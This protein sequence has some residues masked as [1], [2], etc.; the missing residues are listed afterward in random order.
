MLI[1]IIVNSGK[2]NGM[3]PIRQQS[4]TYTHA[5]LLFDTVIVYGNHFFI[6]NT[7]VSLKKTQ[8]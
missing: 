6:S 3:T 1:D 8:F 4:I 7:L 2:N 5:D